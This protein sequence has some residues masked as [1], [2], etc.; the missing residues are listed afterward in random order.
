MSKILLTGGAG[1]IGSHTAVALI[2]AGHS[3][4][5]AD[6][7]YNSD[8]IVID[9]IEKITGVRPDFC[10]CD[11]CNK[12]QVGEIFK[13]NDID[14]VIH[15]AGYKAV[16]ESSE[17]PLE[18]YRNNI[19]AVLTILEAMRESGVSNFVF[20]SSAT[21]YGTD[22]KPPYEENMEK[23]SCSNPYSWTKSMIEQILV[24][25]AAVNPEMS[26]MILRYFNP[27]GAHESGLIGEDPQGIPNNLMP[28]ITQVA[29]GR[30]DKLTVFGGDYNT[31]DGTCIR[32]Y[33]HV[34]DLAEGH[35]KAIEFAMSNKGVEIFNLGTGVPYSVLEVINAFEKASGFSINYTI[36]AR[37]EGDLPG[38][39][40][41]T[42]KAERMLGWSA[43]RTLDDMCRDSWN[44][45]SKNPQGYKGD[46]K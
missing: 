20:S 4:V 21:V 28:F 16:G 1:F 23:G 6:N 2:E 29:V 17:K 33:I 42:A 36:G 37:R 26:V 38:F 3:V 45:Q 34:M 22:N 32:D 9:R 39:W 30:R 44:W 18:Y 41:D 12:S 5:I 46:K 24:D 14:G 7:L 27:V 40:A 13:E 35:L 15:F 8:E 43:T 11:V 25:I 31:A 10:L 19:D